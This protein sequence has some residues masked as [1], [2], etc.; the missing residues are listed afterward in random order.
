MTNGEVEQWRIAITLDAVKAQRALDQLEQTDHRR[1]V[2]LCRDLADGASEHVKRVALRKLGQ[3]GD[4]DDALAEA[5]ALRAL[6][7]PDL[8]DTALFAVGRVGT[9]Q[10][11]PVLLTYAQSGSFTALAAAADQ[12]RTPTEANQLLALARKY[13]LAPGSQGFQLRAHALP[14]L[15]RYSSAEAEQDLLLTAARRY[16]DDFVIK[17]LGDAPVA[18]LEDVRE[19]R[20]IYPQDSV[21][22]KALSRT[23]DQLERRKAM[24]PKQPIDR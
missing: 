15:L 13:V 14:I 3:R 9:A 19:L 21:E 8:Q 16:A 20:L 23:I 10:S 2:V 5:I 24:P 18:V 6:D 17:A 1:F 11:F 22:Y 7:I 12:V 4:R